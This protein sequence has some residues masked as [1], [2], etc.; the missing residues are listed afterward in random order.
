MISKKFHG[1]ALLLW[2]TWLASS[3]LATVKPHALFSD[4]MV[5]QRGSAVPIWGSADTGEKVTVECNGQS[6][7][8]VAAEGRWL[9][10]LKPLKAGGPYTL[11]INNLE[12]KNVLVGEVWVCSGQSNMQWPLYIT[13]NGQADIR[14]AADPSA[15]HGRQQFA[16]SFPSNIF[17]IG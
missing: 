17:Q 15:D 8:T 1:L 9:V 7:A 5:L 14:N 13:E 2:L 3:A 16:L 10:R 6:V 12:I 11:K 4:G